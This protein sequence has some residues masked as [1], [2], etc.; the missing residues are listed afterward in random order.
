[1]KRFFDVYLRKAS[2]L[3]DMDDVDQGKNILEGFDRLELLDAG[4]KLSL[5]PVLRDLGDGTSYADGETLAFECGTLKVS[6]AEW[7]W[8]R[9]EFHNQKC[10]VLFFDP[11]DNTLLVAAYRIQVNVI[12]TAEGGESYMIKLHGKRNMSNTGATDTVLLLAPG[13]EAER[14]L[15]TGHVFD[16]AGKPIE[17]ASI[18][19]EADSEDWGAESDK[20]GNYLLY[21]PAGKYDV[22]CKADDFAETTELGLA[23]GKDDETVLDFT[24]GFVLAEIIPGRAARF[25]AAAH[26]RRQAGA[27]A[28]P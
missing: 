27:E 13:L 6:K 9:E 17:G 14:G 5:E 11:L 8:L 20:D 15:L 10:D 2:T 21:L 24:L 19:A 12:L 1:M 25:G 7:D 26:Q 16:E 22:T 3:I 4:A 23:I 18:V 28:Q